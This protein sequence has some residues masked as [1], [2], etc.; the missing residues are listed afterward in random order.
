MVKDLEHYMSLPY[1]II[2]NTEEDNN[3]SCYVARLQE[4]PY[5][6]GTGDTPEKAINEL[7][8]NQRLK[9]ETDLEMG[10]PI[11]E[12]AKYTGQ[13]HLRVQP[14]IYGSLARMAEMENVSLNQYI[15]TLLSRAVGYAEGQKESNAQPSNRKTKARIA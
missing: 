2:I 1:T 4:V 5:L 14:S 9:F 6:I 10:F 8:I 11:S 12:P 3:G 13:F 15:N 7:K